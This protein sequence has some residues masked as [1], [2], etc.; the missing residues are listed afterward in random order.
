MLKTHLSPQQVADRK[1]KMIKR[2]NKELKEVATIVGINKPL[3]SYVA[4]HSFATNLKFV[5][6]SIPVISEMLGHKTQ[7]ITETYLKAFENSVLDD[8]VKRLL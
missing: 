8:A 6:V 2:Y 5:G 3:S 7:E 4:R 1:T